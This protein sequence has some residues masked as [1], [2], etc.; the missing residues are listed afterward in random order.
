MRLKYRLEPKKDC[1]CPLCMKHYKVLS[2]TI[3]NHKSYNECPKC[4]KKL[5]DKFPESILKDMNGEERNNYLSN[6]LNETMSF[7]V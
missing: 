1:F 3:N 7:M 2:K 5:F 6:R 4:N